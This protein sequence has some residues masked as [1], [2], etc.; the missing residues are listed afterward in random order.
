[1]TAAPDPARQTLEIALAE[2]Q[3]RAAAA[4]NG[5]V[6]C[7]AGA[8]P[9]HSE[10]VRRYRAALE[11]AL[12]ERGTIKLALAELAALDAEVAP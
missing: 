12:I 7:V 1:M 10:R 11:R 9:W 6:R 4:V 5:I 2:V 3:E 8:Q